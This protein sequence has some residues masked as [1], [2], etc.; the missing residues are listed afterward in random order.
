MAVPEQTPYI[1][2][3]GNGSTTSFP[4]TFDCDNPDHLIVTV[5]DTDAVVGSWSLASGNVIFT[6]PPANDA[7]VVF[8][9]S[10]PIQ[11]SASYQQYD[12]SFRPAP[13]NKDFDKIW[14]KLQELGI[15]DWLLWRA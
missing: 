8:K 1:E 9:R 6:A 2:Y 12:N 10:S 13:V 4:L 11:R 14:I 3:T 7:L 15:E 5:N